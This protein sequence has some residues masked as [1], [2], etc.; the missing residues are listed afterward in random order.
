MSAPL[1][2]TQISPDAILDINGKQTYLGNSFTMSIQPVISDTSE[3][4]VC[5]INN[6]KGSGKSLFIFYRNINTPGNPA[7]VTYYFNPTVN[8]L[9]SPTLPVNL[10]TGSTT[11]SVSQCYLGAT[12]SANGTYFSA[13][14][15]SVAFA[16]NLSPFIIDQGSSL[17]ITVLQIFAGSSPY[18]IETAWYEI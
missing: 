13:A 11:T 6:P 8:V 7:V 18:Y 17:L 14:P 9:G 4:P 15:F 10:R 1:T 16:Q 3:D 5:F 2:S 12:F